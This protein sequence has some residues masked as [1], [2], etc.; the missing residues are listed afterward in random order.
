MRAVATGVVLEGV[1]A[2]VVAL[3]EGGDEPE[4]GAPRASMA[5]ERA[6]SGEGEGG[7]RMRRG[8][9]DNF[10][11]QAGAVGGGGRGKWQC[12]WI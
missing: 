4:G 3:A 12:G 8:G 7:S 6:E 9:N 10:D 5:M 1:E 11:W 2:V